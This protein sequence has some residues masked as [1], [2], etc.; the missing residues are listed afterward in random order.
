VTPNLKALA[1]DGARGAMRPSFPSLTYPNHYTLVTGKR[2]DHHGVV[3]N[4]MLDPDHPGARFTMAS[5]EPFWWNQATPL[6][7]TV[8]QQ[9]KRAAAMFWPGSETE[10]QGLR[11]SRWKKFDHD[12][13]GDA[14]VDQLLAW[15]DEADGPPLAF[16]TLY[17]DVVDSQGHRHGPDSPEVRAAAASVDASLGR[18]I[19]GL[20]ARGRY[21]STDIVVVADHGMANVPTANRIMLDDLIDISK[22]QVAGTGPISSFTPAPGAEK[23]VLAVFVKGKPAHMTCWPKGKIPKRFHYGTNP[24]IPAIVCLTETGWFTGVK[25]RQRKDGGELGGMHGYDPYDPTMRAV[26]V[27]H[28]PS[29]KPGV[30]LPVFDN[31]DVYPLLAKITGVTP[32]KGDG[33]LKVV[34]KALR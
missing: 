11:A 8:Q 15:L 34:S 12:M 21:E 3:D 23:E 25:S 18:L 1:D 2:P 4:T 17:F 19:A 16:S 29:F 33:S 22:I 27:A 6:W 5:T 28:G 13:P 14:R 7:I 32:E 10:L 24:R 26:F 30:V 31:V 20:K 9:G